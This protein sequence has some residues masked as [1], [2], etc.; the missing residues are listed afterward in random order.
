MSYKSKPI[1]TLWNKSSS[2]VWSWRYGTIARFLVP[3]ESGQ[4][5][6]L[7]SVNFSIVSHWLP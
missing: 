1:G 3:L 4:R 2:G 6:S 5:A 7:D